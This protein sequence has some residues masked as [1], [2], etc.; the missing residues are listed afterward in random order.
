MRVLGRPLALEAGGHELLVGALVDA[1]LRQLRRHLSRGR[2]AGLCGFGE[3]I[4][5]G[6]GHVLEIRRDEH[7]ARPQLGER[8]L[9]VGL[10]E[11]GEHL[12]RDGQQRSD[13]LALEQ[14][15]ADVDRDHDIDPELARDVDRQVAREAAIDQQSLFRLDRIHRA[16]DRHAGANG[17]GEAPF[18]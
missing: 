5:A 11:D 4:E 13:L 3:A 18:G 1:V 16:G 6:R 7:I 10:G 2:F 15:R 14:R 17:G 9:D 12:L 8:L